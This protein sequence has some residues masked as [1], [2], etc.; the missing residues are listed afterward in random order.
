MPCANHIRPGT[1]LLHMPPEKV[2]APV[3]PTSWPLRTLASGGLCTHTFHRH[4]DCSAR[5]CGCRLWE[6][7][8]PR[9]EP[10]A[11]R[12]PLLSMLL[13][14][15]TLVCRVRDA[16][17]LRRRELSPGL[18][19]DRRKLLTTILQRMPQRTLS[20]TYLQSPEC[21]PSHHGIYWKKWSSWQ[22]WRKWLKILGAPALD[23]LPMSWHT[24][25]HQEP[26]LSLPRLFRHW[27][28]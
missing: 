23:F 9:T 10:P 15:G 20:A 5:P 28:W 27:W 6:E 2:D 4:R 13:Y 3:S 25:P 1:Q 12:E 11:P 24:F 19:R 7:T 8:L 26:S 18:P 21:W 16:S 14:P 22:G 17:Y